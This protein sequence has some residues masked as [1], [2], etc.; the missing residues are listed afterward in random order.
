M[1]GV[2]TLP[3]ATNAGPVSPVRQCA[4]ALVTSHD[5]QRAID[6]FTKAIANA[7]SGMQVGLSTARLARGTP[8]VP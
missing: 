7:R 1:W 6:Y 8:R 3:A 4:R 2:G 5:Y